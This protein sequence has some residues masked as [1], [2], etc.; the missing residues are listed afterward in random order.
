[1]RKYL[2]FVLVLGSGL[3]FGN[4]S[5]GQEQ[6]NMD[7]SEFEKAIAKPGA[8]V[9]DVRTM[10]EFQSGHLKDALLADWTIKEQFRERVAALDKS[11][12]VYTY[13]LSGGR[14]SAA[15]QWLRENGYTTYNMVG[16]ISKWKQAGKPVEA[17]IKGR[18]ISVAEYKS[19]IPVDKVVLVDVS[20]TWCPPCKKMKPVI[21]SLVQSGSK[22]FTLVEIDGG[23]QTEL[24]KQLAVEAFPT[25]IIYKNGKETWRTSGVT[26][27]AEL[28]KHL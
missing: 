20:A 21:D 8:Q 4:N 19:M 15:A 12:P 2:F 16:G 9:L 18:Q 25:F 17:E 10:D 3:L 28:V 1:M 6:V 24:I 7:V 14:S 22:P 27:P 26:D 5:F 13:C 23:G 11:K